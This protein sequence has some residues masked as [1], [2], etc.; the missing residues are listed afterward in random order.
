[1]RLGGRLSMS[2]QKHRLQPRRAGCAPWLRI[3]ACL[4]ALALAPAA[5]PLA[6][7]GGTGPSG[8]T[9]T[10]STPLFMP[11]GEGGQVQ[12]GDFVTANVASMAGGGGNCDTA[13]CLQ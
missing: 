9:S 6:H 5:A 8:A 11:Q 7:A 10:T 3:A 13:T 2:L 1:M 4:T 12:F